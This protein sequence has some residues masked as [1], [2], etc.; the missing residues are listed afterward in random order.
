MQT[1]QTPQL[2]TDAEVV[3]ALWSANIPAAYHKKT[4]SLKNLPEPQRAAI[5][6]W[7]PNARLDAELGKTLECR[8]DGTDGMDAVCL[9]ARA[10]VLKGQSVFVL[11]VPRLASLL[12]NKHESFSIEVLED[13]SE[14]SYLFLLGSI[15]H[16]THPYPNPLNFEMDWFLRNWMMSNKSL[17]M[18]G[19]GNL[20]LCDWW[21]AGFRSLFNSRKVLTIEGTPIRLAKGS[22]ATLA[23]KGGA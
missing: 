16:G 9:L 10:L 4:S 18:Q 17:L 12:Q 8:L 23:K 2:L 13:L 3:K 19:E 7:L 6:A 11:T 15:G 14:R 20:D 5:E 22:F 1:D 21:S